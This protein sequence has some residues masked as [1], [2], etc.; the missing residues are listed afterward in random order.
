MNI[1]PHVLA[2][3][4]RAN[5]EA[6]ES[7][8]RLGIDVT[9][10]RQYPTNCSTCGAWLFTGNTT[11]QCAECYDDRVCSC[12]RYPDV[13]APDC[14]QHGNDVDGAPMTLSYYG[15]VTVAEQHSIDAGRPGR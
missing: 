13:I 5:R 4:E 10:H 9:E 15:G 12:Y 3:V 11:G 8:A 14:P 2:Q 7:H 1:D 6:A